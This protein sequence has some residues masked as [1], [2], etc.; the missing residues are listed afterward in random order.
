MRDS[1]TA[2]P[3]NPAEGRADLDLPGADHGH[4][5]R[6]HGPAAEEAGDPTR[7]DVPVPAPGQPSTPEAGRRD[8]LADRVAAGMPSPA[9]RDRPDVLPDVEVPEEQA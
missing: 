4:A 6:E 8:E 3:M 2:N 5:V 9:G 7:P 1:S